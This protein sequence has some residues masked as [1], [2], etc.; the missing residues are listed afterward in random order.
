MFLRGQIFYDATC[1]LCAESYRK[2]GPM[3][4]RRGF[5][6]IPMQ[7]RRAQDI[8]GIEDGQIPDELK[9]LTR[10]GQVL[11]G[12]DG[13]LYIG[14]YVWW[15]FPVWLLSRLPGVRPILRLLY[16]LVARN[17]HRVSDACGFDPSSGADGG[18][19]SSSATH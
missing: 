15:A 19:T 6:W 14:R 2:F 4:E 11:G 13:L 17:R 9:L 18:S 7:D 3:T 10:R 5:R 12:V 1:G 16:R 8:L